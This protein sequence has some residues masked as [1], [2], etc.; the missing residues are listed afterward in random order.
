LYLA[1]RRSSTYG[2][3]PDA[4]GAALG[5]GTPGAG[6]GGKGEG[7]GLQ[8][9]SFPFGSLGAADAATADGRGE[10]DDEDDDD[11]DDEAATLQIL[12]FCPSLLVKHLASRLGE[13]VRATHA[14]SP[15]YPPTFTHMCRS[16]P[17]VGVVGGVGVLVRRGL[18]ARG[19]LGLLVLLVVQVFQG[20]P[21]PN[22]LSR[23]LFTLI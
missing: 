21:S 23:L 6:D 20:A 15:L 4:V 2:A 11:D 10:D 5:A 16:C 7:L 14:A 1:F 22:P 3:G 19:H 12:S 18:H 17:C 9:G 13:E 8:R